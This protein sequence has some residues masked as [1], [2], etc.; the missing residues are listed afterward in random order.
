MLTPLL[1]DLQTKLPLELR[2]MVYENLVD[3]HSPIM[4]PR[5]EKT[6]QPE[7]VSNP[8]IPVPR[9]LNPLDGH[10][11]FDVR[12]VGRQIANETREYFLR[13]TPLF[14]RGSGNLATLLELTAVPGKQIQ[15]VTRHLR[16]Y[17]RAEAFETELS[18]FLRGLPDVFS[19]QAERRAHGEARMYDAYAKRLTALDDIPFKDRKIKLEICILHEFGI[20]GAGEEEGEAERANAYHKYNVL[21][22]IKHTYFKA[23]TSGAEITVRYENSYTG[24][25]ADVT[26]ELD[27]DSER[28]Q[29]VSSYGCAISA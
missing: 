1:H 7:Y 12:V 5:S 4:I 15:D 19:S 26:W 17:V 14:F 20:W 23:K 2:Q 21:E 28:W 16:V 8:S 10:F 25:G 9:S 13:R 27:A 3:V 18:G 24:A 6:A 22:A 29:E 11:A